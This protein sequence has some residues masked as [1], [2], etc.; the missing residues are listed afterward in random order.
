MYADESGDSGL[1]GS[2]TPYFALSGLV[3][4]ESQWRACVTQ[5]IAF[6]KTLKAA[7][8]LPQRT[9]IHASE[10]IRRPPVPGMP[11][12]VRMAI[13]RNMLDELSTMKFVSVTNVIV[14]K[15]GKPANYDV[16][17][18]AW[19]ALFQRFENTLKF[20][21]FPGAHRQDHGMILT[22]A[23]N[24]T[25]LRKL[26]RRMSVYN[27]IPHQQWAGPGARNIPILRI[28]EDPSERNSNDSYF[29]QACDVIA[30]FVLQSFH[31]CS[32]VRRG[33]ARNYVRRL[34]PVLNLRASHANQLGI[35]IL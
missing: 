11:K 7:Y 26:V 16:F 33:G 6:R 32:Y 35:V 30:Y 27:P 5:L 20:G 15:A 2:P 4:H 13:L 8:G 12:H 22:D 24:G 28:I 23:T 17:G 34:G 19:Q 9:E 1:V 3:V 10:Y 29:I 21:N 31:P 18:N 25:M 14:S